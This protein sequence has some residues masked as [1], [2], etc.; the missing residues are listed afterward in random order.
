MNARLAAAAVL[1]ALALGATSADAADAKARGAEP[2][3]ATISVVRAEQGRLV[4]SL[5][6]TGTLVA[7]EEVLV[8]PQIDGLAIL[9]IAAEEGDR[10]AAGQVLARLARETIDAL[11][12]Q[13]AAQIVRAEAAIAQ[14]H[15]QIAESRANHAQATSSLARARA[16]QAQGNATL[17]TLEQRQALAQVWTARIVSAENAMRLAEADKVVAEA[18]RRELLIRAARTEIKAPVAGIVSRRSARLGAVVAMAADPLFRV[19]ADG[20]VELEADVAETV[21]AKL[22]VGQGATIETVSREEQVAGRVRLVA[23]E[24]S[25]AT[26]LGRVRIALDTREALTIGSFARAVVRVAERDGVLVPISAVQFQAGGAR[27]QVVANGVVETRNVS[28]GLKADRR[29]QILSGL[30]AGE[31]IVLVSGAMVRPGDRVTTILAEPR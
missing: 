6:V 31:H 21:L 5:A 12:D 25:R 15:S 4:E 28:V 27:L 2:K 30:V 3:P 20:E 9:E 7:R 1:A 29:A 13:N 11:L 16:L 26:R 19:I 22:R 17:D 23:P 24:I 10:V 14:A 8:S 18:Q